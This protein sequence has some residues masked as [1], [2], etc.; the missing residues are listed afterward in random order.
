MVLFDYER[1]LFLK[2]SNNKALTGIILALWIVVGCLWEVVF[3]YE[4]WLHMKVQLY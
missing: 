3:N 4:R 1:W 2:G